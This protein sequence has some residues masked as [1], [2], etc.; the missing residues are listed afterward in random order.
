[1]YERPCVGKHGVMKVVE[2]PEIEEAENSSRQANVITT[3]A[4]QAD[5]CGG[6]G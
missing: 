1:M 6:P 5:H 3:C 4:L 2:A